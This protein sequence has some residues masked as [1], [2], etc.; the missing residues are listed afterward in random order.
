MTSE[1]EKILGRGLAIPF[2]REG[3]D[4]ANAE[5]KDNIRNAIR[6]AL[7]TRKGELRWNPSFGG[8]PDRLR[9]KGITETLLATIQT[10]ITQSLQCIPHMEITNISV[11]QREVGS[12]TI[13]AEISWRGVAS[14]GTRN[15]VITD[16]EITEVEI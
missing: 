12:K 5:G 4:F 2:Q 9:H 16:E 14:S 7:M 6:Q 13:I 1:V 15:T 11:R 8:S 10:D 3:N